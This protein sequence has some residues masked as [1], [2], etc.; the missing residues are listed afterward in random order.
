[1]TPR[2]GRRRPPHRPR[3]GLVGFFGWGNYGD[4]LFLQLWRR[5]LSPHFEVSPV[6]DLLMEPYV[7]GDPKVVAARYDAFVIGGG[8]LIIPNGVS[9]LYWK[10][11]WLERKVYIVGVG[12]AIWGHRHLPE[13]IEEMSEFF[14]H[15]NVQFISARDEASADWIRRYLRPVVPVSVHPDLV[16]ASRIPPPRDYGGRKTLGISVR[17]GLFNRDHDFG[18]L[19]RL[20]TVARRHGYGISVIELGSGRQRRRDARAIRRLPFIPDEVV[21]S[22]DVNVLSAAIGGLDAFASMKFH[23]LVVALMYGVPALAL[24]PNAKNVGLLAS[25]DRPDLIGDLEGELDLSLRFRRLQEPVD[26]ERVSGLVDES[27]KALETLIRQMLIQLAPAQLV[28]R[29][30]AQAVELVRDVLPDSIRLGRRRLQAAGSL[31]TPRAHPGQITDE[32]EGDAAG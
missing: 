28:P 22:A 6:N 19:D 12:V 21:S 13:V 4:E 16:F 17:Q 32:A 10:R 8:D 11:E 5:V 25:I 15:P 24:T 18:Q 29:T 1:M 2:G 30:P 14:R 20:V 7:V 9:G 27:S 26:R 3:V 23:G 31:R